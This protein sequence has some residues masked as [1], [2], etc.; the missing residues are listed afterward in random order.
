MLSRFSGANKKQASPPPPVLEL[1]GEILKHA[2]ER[3]ISAS[4]QHG[5]IERFVYA[6]TLK[7]KLFAESFSLKSPKMPDRTTFEQL[8]CFMPTVR[9]R[10]A[11][12]IEDNEKFGKLS[13][14][15][16]VL[17]DGAED[18]LG[19]D[20]RMDAFISTFPGD[21]EHRWIRDLAAEVLHG[22]DPERYPMMTRWVWDTSANTGVLRE[23][24]FGNNVDHQV[25]DIADNF[26]TFITL[27]AELSQ[28]LSD[29]GIF[30]DMLPLVDL[31]LAQIY[32][33]YISEHGS[34]YIRADFTNPEDPMLHV[35]R[36][37]G[38]DG[39]S[40]K[41]KSRLKTIDGTSIIFENL[42]TLN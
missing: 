42:K 29:N 27:R 31:L 22:C 34:T 25:I 35:R 1:S 19:T 20:A 12:Y 17:L 7:S 6:Q 30:R 28:Y 37:L 10:I 11:P 3:L 18:T 4:D 33:N 13:G 15:L 23:I 32:A 21:R 26:E 9:R 39:V 41:G 14:A 24:W 38:L 40:S 8:C 36:L 5:G 16:M 2:L